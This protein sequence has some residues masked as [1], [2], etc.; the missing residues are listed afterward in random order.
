[1]LIRPLSQ[2]D[3]AAVRKLDEQILGPDRSE[4]WDSYLD[5]FLAVVEMDSLPFPPWGC[6]VAE[7]GDDLIGFLFSERQSTVYGLPP[8]ARIVA[9]AVHPEH[10]HKEVATSLVNSLI[11]QCENEGIDQVFAAL[12]AADKRDAVFLRSLGFDGA[13]VRV[14]VKQIG[15]EGANGTGEDV[16]EKRAY[17]A[18]VERVSEQLKRTQDR[19]SDALNTALQ[20]ASEVSSI[21]G[22]F[23]SEQLERAS[24]YVRR[25]LFSLSE[26][27]ERAAELVKGRLR[28]SR[29]KN[30]F[31]ALAGEAFERAGS[32][33]TRLSDRIERPLKFE[34]GEVT[35]PGTLTCTA[36]D[37]QMRFQNS[38]RIP[39]C[40]KCHKT[41]FKKGY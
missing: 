37:S 6:F 7:E 1:M 30:S 12:L 36:C 20:R 10:R 41:S 31:L 13:A 23:T 29:V 8:G 11:A 17:D 21:A 38:G 16:A 5:R 9:I 24:G 3:S 35:G 28:P 26:N 15:A 33:L 32:G 34:T 2:S 25:D 14:Y 19:G 27:R 22:E 39:P 18:I 40:P 4:T